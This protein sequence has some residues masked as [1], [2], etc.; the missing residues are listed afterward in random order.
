MRIRKCVTLVASPCFICF[1]ALSNAWPLYLLIFFFQWTLSSH[2]DISSTRARICLLLYPLVL[3]KLFKT[4]TAWTPKHQ[5]GHRSQHTGWMSAF[6]FL[7]PA[8]QQSLAL[9]NCPPKVWMNQ[10]TNVSWLISLLPHEHRSI[11]IKKGL[12]G[13]HPVSRPD[14]HASW[15]SWFSSTG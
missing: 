2:E 15:G 7:F 11:L 5:K 8:S 6:L 4:V 12:L 10:S 13:T 1:M 9:N 14:L 3:F